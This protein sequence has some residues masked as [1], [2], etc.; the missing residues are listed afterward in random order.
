MIGSAIRGLARFMEDPSGTLAALREVA[1][2][3]LLGLAA[4]TA[5]TLAMV[6]ARLGPGVFLPTDLP[7]PGGA[8][9]APPFAEAMR[10]LLS[11]LGVAAALWMAVRLHGGA[12]I[13]PTEAVWMTIP[14]ALALV[15]LESCRAAYAVLAAA[16]GGPLPLLAIPGMT[17]LIALVI[18]VLA[19]TV[20]ALSPGIGWL[21]ALGAGALAFSVGH[22]HPWL[23][24]AGAG[25]VLFLDARRPAR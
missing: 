17:G 21:R 11:M 16:A 12:R 10:A 3:F 2:P 4:L 20:H 6:V 22:F 9:A 18:L 14:Y 15:A 19:A 23:V 25:T 5:C 24:L 1:P 13:R 7:P 8:E